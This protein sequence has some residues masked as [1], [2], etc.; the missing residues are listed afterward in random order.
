MLKGYKTYTGLLLIVLGMT[1]ATKYI[2]QEEASNMLDKIFQIINL[3][4]EV[5]GV[6]L[7]VVGAIHKD[8]RL[9]KPV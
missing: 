3:S 5:G 7:A 9:K 8:I 2:S 1:G 6:L 4:L